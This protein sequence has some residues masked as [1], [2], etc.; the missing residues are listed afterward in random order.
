MNAPGRDVGRDG[1]YLWFLPEGRGVG[2]AEPLTISLRRF[3]PFG[4]KPSNLQLSVNKLLIR[5][6]KTD[7]SPR[8][9]GG[10]LSERNIQVFLKT[11][12]PFRTL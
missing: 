6:R 2:C 11:T 1:R 8:S 3:P 7:A 12:F 10:D 9:S 4:D 5:R